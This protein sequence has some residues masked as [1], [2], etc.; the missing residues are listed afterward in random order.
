MTGHFGEALF[1][2]VNLPFIFSIDVSDISDDKQSEQE[3]IGK[4]KKD[5][6]HN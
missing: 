6:E 5:C 3:N 4:G 2:K 1:L